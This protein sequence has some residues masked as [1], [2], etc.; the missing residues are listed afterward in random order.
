LRARRTHSLA[1][2]SPLILVH[3]YVKTHS[4]CTYIWRTRCI[5][6][7]SIY[8]YRKHVRSCIETLTLFMSIYIYMYIYIDVYI[9]SCIY[10]YVHINTYIH[11]QIPYM[12]IH[13]KEH[14]L[15]CRR[16]RDCYHSC[17]S[18]YKYTHI[19]VFIYVYIYTYIHTCMYI[20]TNIN[21]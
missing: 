20:Y 5:Y 9:Y 18:I 16:A 14:I 3:V 17:L 8:I 13:P 1:R 11:V 6:T 21:I 2:A 12:Y 4:T 10:M 7:Y 19:Y 15:S